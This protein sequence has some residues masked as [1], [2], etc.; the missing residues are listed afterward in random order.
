M[1][2]EA[3]VSSMNTSR[4]GSRSSCP[5][6]QASRRVKTSGRSCSAACADFFPC[7]LPA[8]EEAPQRTDA[9]ANPALGQLRLQFVRR[10]VRHRLD[11][12]E[13]Q[14]GMSLDLTRSFVSALRKGQRLSGLALPRA[15]GSRSRR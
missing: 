13:D 4:A 12:P 6:N 14:I 7:Y 8:R 11:Q 2:V 5:S 3:Q 10:H 1:L 15:I 9:D